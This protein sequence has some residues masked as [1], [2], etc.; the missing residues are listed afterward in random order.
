MMTYCRR[1]RTVFLG[2]LLTVARD[3]AQFSFSATD[4]LMNQVKTWLTFIRRRLLFH[5][6]SA[7]TQLDPSFAQTS[8]AMATVTSDKA[9]EVDDIYSRCCL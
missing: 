2:P 3:E 5:R 8:V 6:L 4:L 1:I 7:E 9:K